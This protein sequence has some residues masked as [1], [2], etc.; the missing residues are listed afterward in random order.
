MQQRNLH[1]LEVKLQTLQGELSRPESK[2][3]QHGQSKG[4][5]S[6]FFNPLWQ[7]MSSF[8]CVQAQTLRH[9]K[10]TNEKHGGKFLGLLQED[11]RTTL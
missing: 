2:K 4:G 7:I 6:V 5:E 10:S 8:N 1:I 11:T 9:H 3:I